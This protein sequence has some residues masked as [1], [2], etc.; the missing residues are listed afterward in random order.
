MITLYLPLFLSILQTTTRAI[1]LGPLSNPTT[2]GN[3]TNTSLEIPP[4][5]DDNTTANRVPDPYTR[6][7][8][9]LLYIFK[10]YRP[11][12]IHFREARE[13]LIDMQQWVSRTVCLF[14]LCSFSS[15]YE[16]EKKRKEKKISALLPVTSL[17]PHSLYT[18]PSISSASI[19]HPPNSP[20]RSSLKRSHPL[21]FHSA[22][23][24]NESI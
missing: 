5:L 13:D 2:V 23:A 7:G 21:P 16:I 11:P 9:V 6:Q 19:S 10:N 24:N 3:I 15:Q 17:D 22:N 4:P 20:S 18:S 8:S 1:P 14:A 12:Y